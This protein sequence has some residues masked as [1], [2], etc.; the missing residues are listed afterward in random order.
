MFSK[1]VLLSQILVSPGLLVNLLIEVEEEEGIGAVGG[2][3]LINYV[4][5]IIHSRSQSFINQT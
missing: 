4:N 3:L 1:L 5:H 2:E